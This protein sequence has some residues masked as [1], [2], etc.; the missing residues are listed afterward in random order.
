MRFE[1]SLT[2]IVILL[3]IIVLIGIVALTAVLLYLRRRGES[4]RVLK[5]RV[6]ELQA[7]SE[8]VRAIASTELDEDALCNLTYERVAQL[9]DA[10]TFQLGLFEGDDYITKLR[11]TRGNR[12]PVERFNLKDSPGIVGW[13][14]KFYYLK[15]YRL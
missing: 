14:F 3:V 6:A 2:L 5:E 8:S 13:I 7:L 12:Q 15:L 11:F 1:S 4:S 10:Q 9:V